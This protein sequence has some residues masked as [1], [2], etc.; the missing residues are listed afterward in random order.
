LSAFPIAATPL[1]PMLFVLRLFGKRK[2]TDEDN[3]QGSQERGMIDFP[4][5]P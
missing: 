1:S 5:S 2:D 3:A 4:H